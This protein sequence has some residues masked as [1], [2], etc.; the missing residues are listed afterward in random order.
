M[1][2]ELGYDIGRLV[3]LRGMHGA[4][5]TGAHVGVENLVHGSADGT[6]GTRLRAPPTFP[7]ENEHY[8]HY[9]LLHHPLGEHHLISIVSSSLDAAHDGLPRLGLYDIMNSSKVMN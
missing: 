6:R 4:E 9:V 1:F 3:Q 5:Q 2:V 8:A 7:V